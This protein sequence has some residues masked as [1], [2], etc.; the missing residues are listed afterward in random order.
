MD[1][2]RGAT[3]AGYKPFLVDTTR[4]A[5]DAGYKPFLVDTTRGATD[6]GYKPFLVDTT[7]GATD[8]GYK[9]FLV[10]TT[11][12]APDSG[13]EILGP[14]W[15]AIA[16]LKLGSPQPVRC[17]PATVCH[18]HWVQGIRDHLKNKTATMAP[19][20]QK[21]NH[22]KRPVLKLGCWKVRALMTGLSASLQDIKDSS[23]TAVINDE[24]RRLNVDIATFLETR[25]E[26]SGT[27]KEKHY[28]FFGRGSALTS[29]ESTE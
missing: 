29:P 9:P 21:R 15:T 14:Q 20:N 27:L 13:R 4:G 25:L 5:T 10:D 2:T 28:T 26:D 24:L 18:P 22:Q 8:A 7:R 17:C 16:H 19:G 12:A 3:D 1:T 23:K 11:D 6:A